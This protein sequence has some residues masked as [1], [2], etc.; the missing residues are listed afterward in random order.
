V[1]V[2]GLPVKLPQ[3]AK[4]PASC[5]I[6]DALIPILRQDVYEVRFHCF[7]VIP[8]SVHAMCKN[9]NYSNLLSLTISLAT[10]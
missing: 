3:A 10:I 6:E 9:G 5:K 4:T 1:P 8:V 7:G 2:P